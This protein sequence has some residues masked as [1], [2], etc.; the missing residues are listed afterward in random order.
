MTKKKVRRAS[1]KKGRAHASA[2]A[3]AKAS[4]KT[5]DGKVIVVQGASSSGGGGSAGG[6]SASGGSGGG[7]A[8]PPPSYY[9]TPGVQQVAVPQAVGQMGAAPDFMAAHQ[10][11]TDA[12]ESRLAARLHDDR[13]AL[14]RLA[15]QVEHINNFH[16]H[17][18]QLPD[19]VSM[20]TSDG[21]PPPVQLPDDVSMQPSGAS[22]VRSSHTGRG[23]ASVSHH[24]S[25]PVQ[26]PD[27]VSTLTS[28][29]SS[30]RS[31][32][33]GHSRTPSTH[34]PMGAAS[35]VED[36]HVPG[37]PVQP[38]I[39]NYYHT[40]YD[41]RADQRQVHLHAGQADEEHEP[42]RD[43][44]AEVGA[45]GESVARETSTRG[46]TLIG[47]AVDTN[48]PVV[49]AIA[50]TPAVH[51]A[52]HEVAASSDS[53]AVGVQPPALL[54]PGA[55]EEEEFQLVSY[56]PDPAPLETD[57]DRQRAHWA[58]PIP[59]EILRPIPPFPLNDLLSRPVPVRSGENPAK[60]VAIDDAAIP[61]EGALVPIAA[62]APARPNRRSR[63]RTMVA[64]LRGPR[65]PMQPQV[66]ADELTEPDP[67]TLP[68]AMEAARR[69]RM[70]YEESN[71][72]AP[73]RV[74]K[75]TKRVAKPRITNGSGK[76]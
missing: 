59:A 61:Q 64:Q 63:V 40:Y 34:T 55:P 66:I 12:F 54:T 62:E 10:A 24:S 7:H 44:A 69:F 48:N 21:P 32:H 46:D 71:G 56:G 67:P 51:H 65:P 28:G 43:A 16:L 27:E 35:V 52:S 58:G 39:N 1:K 25:H 76:G 5:R 72:G 75:A 47:P 11:Y 45:D 18:F 30:V 41:S 50:P 4:A 26:L 3:S 33:T 42:G 57:E 74:V 17:P 13:A 14:D 73:K 70:W 6:G 38:T 31:S 68:P 15:G 19:D 36:A 37:P 29:T 60:R 20:M 8:Y 9:Q 49:D 22:S 2:R 53:V 23:R